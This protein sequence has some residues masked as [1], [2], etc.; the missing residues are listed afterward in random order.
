MIRYYDRNVNAITPEAWTELFAERKYRVIAESSIGE[1]HIIT[2][3]TGL[4]IADPPDPPIIFK[5]IIF[6]GVRKNTGIL[7]I[8]YQT[9]ARA[10]RGHTSLALGVGDAMADS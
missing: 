5:T 3:W 9:E 7:A 6:N 2:T 8:C 1:W 4:D 10:I